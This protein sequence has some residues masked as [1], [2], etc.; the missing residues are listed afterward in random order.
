MTGSYYH[1]KSITFS[2]TYIYIHI[3]IY[4]CITL[5]GP[6][7]APNCV[8]AKLTG[9]GETNTSSCLDHQ[10]DTAFYVR[11][12]AFKAM[13]TSI[14]I[15]FMCTGIHSWILGFK[16]WCKYKFFFFLFLQMHII[17]LIKIS[18]WNTNSFWDAIRCWSVISREIFLWFLKM[19][20]EKA[21]E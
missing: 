10:E 4:L 18:T 14:E 16:K 13:A 15:F 9:K 3:F 2:C 1:G 7:A 8:K 20:D 17:F 19:K 5:P 12:R 11:S 21:T 6:L